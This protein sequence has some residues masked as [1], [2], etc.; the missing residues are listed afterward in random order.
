MIK[1][2]VIT[3]DKR[4]FVVG[5]IHGCYDLLMSKL[6]EI[7]FDFNSDLLIGVGDLID[8]GVENLK[9]VELLDKGW[10]IN[11]RGNHE[12]FCIDGLNDPTIAY[13]HKMR[14]NCGEWFYKLSETTQRNIVCQFE[15]LPLMLEVDYCGV[16]FGFVHAGLPVEDW[17]LCKELLANGDI[18]QGR[19]MSEHL[20]WSRDLINSGKHVSVAGINNVFFGHTVIPKAKQLGNCIFLDTGGV[21]KGMEHWCD[22]TIVNLKDYV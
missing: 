1:Q 20:L 16:K 2:L 13:Y 3:D 15:Q 19:P 5:D 12:Q 21:F 10:F 17:E 9:C 18:W 8:K 11:V 7:D 6:R 22:L 4:V 14:N